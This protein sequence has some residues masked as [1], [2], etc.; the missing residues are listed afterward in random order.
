VSWLEDKIQNHAENQE[1]QD[2]HRDHQ[3]GKFLDTALT[4]ARLQK[5][6]IALFGR[7]AVNYGFSF[8]HTMQLRPN[9]RLG[10]RQIL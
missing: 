5:I 2:D 4:I 10:K 1:C 7:V 9:L 6:G 3:H 8:P